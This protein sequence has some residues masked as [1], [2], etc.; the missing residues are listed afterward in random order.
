[1]D[2]S[3]FVMHMTNFLH[4]NNAKNNN[5]FKLYKSIICHTSITCFYNEK[6]L[7]A[8]FATKFTL[9][10]LDFIYLKNNYCFLAI[11]IYIVLISVAM[12]Q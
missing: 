1:M 9:P 4:L 2:I 11:N 6:Q 7:I 8:F 3:L 10:L 5:N 12:K